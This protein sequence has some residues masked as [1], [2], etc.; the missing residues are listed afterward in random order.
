LGALVRHPD[1]V[2]KADRQLRAL[3]LPPLAAD[4]FSH[5]DY[6][7]IFAALKSALDQDQIEPNLH[8]NLHLDESLTS[9]LQTL[10]TEA[11]PIM[12]EDQQRVDDVLFAV[13]RLRDRSVGHA[14]NEVR[15]LQQEA[16]DEP[17]MAEVYGRQ[18]MSLTQ[19][20]QSL[21][22]A[23]KHYTRRMERLSGMGISQS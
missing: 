4:D 17:E 16:Q 20:K 6:Q 13:I 3:S 1:L 8:V 19:A 11:E 22:R 7:I 5:T 15:F 23:R 21:T 10:V 18:A 14:L 12:L 2:A 9:R